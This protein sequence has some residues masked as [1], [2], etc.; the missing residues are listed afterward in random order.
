MKVLKYIYIFILE[1]GSIWTFNAI[2]ITQ[3]DE[4]WRFPIHLSSLIISMIKFPFEYP[5]HNEWSV[6]TPYFISFLNQWTNNHHRKVEDLWS[7][8]ERSCYFDCPLVNSILLF[9]PLNP[10]VSI[11]NWFRQFRT[12][13]NCMLERFPLDL[14]PSFSSFS[15]KLYFSSYF[16]LIPDPRFASSSF[17]VR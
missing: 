13:N 7:T 2:I 12:K 11:V 14:Q 9:L 1:L 6:F 16:Y 8:D 4:N 15:K 17:D 3:F 10:V 5:L